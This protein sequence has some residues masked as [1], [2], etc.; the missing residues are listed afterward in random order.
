M[1]RVVWFNPNT[2]SAE[3]FVGSL[4]G[5]GARYLRFL[6]DGNTVSIPVGF[7]VSVT[8]GTESMEGQDSPQQS[9]LASAMKQTTTH[10]R[11]A[12]GIDPR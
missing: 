8:S 10:G 3:E 7:L 1:L 5:F 4:I 2:A 12:S 6:R 9:T 11:Q